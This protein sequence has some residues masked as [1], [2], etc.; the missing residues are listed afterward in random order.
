MPLTSLHPTATEH[1]V[2]RRNA[3]SGAGAAL[4]PLHL[5]HLASFDAP[6]VALVWASSFTW[7]VGTHLPPQAAA[8]IALGVWT[9]YVADRLLDARSALRHDAEY[10][11]RERHY[12]HWR[13]RKV[14]VPFALVAGV[15]VAILVL[16]C[17]PVVARERDSVLAV[18]SLA[19]FA[20]VHQRELSAVRGRRPFFPP[21]IT[22]ELLVGVLFAVGCALP[23]LGAAWAAAAISRW[24]LMGCVAFFAALAWLNCHAIEQWESEAG[25][26][27]GT[28]GGSDLSLARLAFGLAS[29]SLLAAVLLCRAHP[30][31]ALLLAAAA[32]SALLIA[33]LDRMRTRLNPLTLR[34]AADVVLLAPALV[35]L[36]AG[37]IAGLVR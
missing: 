28:L 29:I 36:V 22:K 24:V 30:R 20:R 21:M 25:P 17:I 31:P 7:A 11:L 37:P 8:V 34:A 14:L 13:H 15:A 32:I 4:T 18:A 12:F 3:A 23:A 2:E 6:T 33:L 19:Y 26:E 10:R 9:V 16:A 35:I 27:P 5:W 1:K